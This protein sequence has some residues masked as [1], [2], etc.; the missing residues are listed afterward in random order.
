M[1]C[2]WQATE[3]VSGHDL[4][5]KGCGIINIH[6]TMSCVTMCH[7]YCNQFV[8][9]IMGIIRAQFDF[10]FGIQIMNIRSHKQQY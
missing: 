7:N 3:T 6:I 5:H 1:K 9:I 10:Y 4:Q 2:K 8:L